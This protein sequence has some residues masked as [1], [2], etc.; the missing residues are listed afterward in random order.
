MNQELEVRSAYVK[1]V[2]DT[3]VQQEARQSRFWV[4]SG[5]VAELI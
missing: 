2:S 5:I 4:L 1:C 3:R